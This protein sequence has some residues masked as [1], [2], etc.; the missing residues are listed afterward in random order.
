MLGNPI[1][2]RQMLDNL[3]GNAVKYTPEGGS[4]VIRMSVEEEQLIT[5]IKDS[6]IGIPLSD[7]AHIFDKFYRASNA[8]KGVAGNRAGPGHCQVHRG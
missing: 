1:R 4:V 3:I 6:G 5:S 2:L 7:Q 8:P